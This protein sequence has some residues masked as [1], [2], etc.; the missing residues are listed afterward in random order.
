M[1]ADK[2]KNRGE[3]MSVLEGMDRLQYIIDE[4]RKVEPLL[5]E[6]K[7]DSNKIR[8][9]I[10]NLWVA[11]EVMED[12]TMKYY[13]DADSHMTKGTAKVILDI[14]NGEKKNEVATLTLESF[15]PLGIGELLTMQRQVGFA[16]LIERVIRIAKAQ[17]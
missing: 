15:M 3:E 5:D 7:T 10:S 1:I 12:G 17:V 8:G 6:H 11:G 13:H 9:C 14:V 4:A 16:S 2:I